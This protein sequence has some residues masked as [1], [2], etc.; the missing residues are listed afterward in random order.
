MTSTERRRDSRSAAERPVNAS[1]L[2]EL[3]GKGRF[4]LAGGRVLVPDGRMSDAILLDGDRIRAIGHRATD[5]AMAGESVRVID[6]S[7]LAVAPGFIDGHT[8]LLHLGLKLSR[9]DLGGAGSSEEVLARVR[10]ALVVHDPERPLVAEGWDDGGWQAGDR[11]ERQELDRLSTRIPI[12]LRRV[13]GHKAVAN[14]AALEHVLGHPDGAAHAAAG[15]IDSAAGTLVEAAAMRLAPIFPPSPAERSTA[16]DLAYRHAAQCGVTGVHD[17]VTTDALRE[18]QIRRR[19]GRLTLRITAHVAIEQLDAL[20]ELGLASGLGDPWLR[21][22]GV[23]LYLDGSLGARTAALSAPYAGR[24]VESGLL[25]IDEEPLAA[26]IRRLDSLGLTAVIHAIGDRAVAAAIDALEGLGAERVREARHRIEHLEL[27]PDDLVERMARC[28]AVA[29]MQP[30][31]VALWGARGG[32]YESV[33]GGSRWRLMN[34]FRSLAERG[35]PLAFGSDCM[36]MGP[37]LGLRGA[38]QHPVEVERLSPAD[39][40]AAYTH[41]SA[42]AGFAERDTGTIEIGKLA[43]LVLL[44]SDPLGGDVPASDRVD[45]SGVVATIVGGRLVFE[46]EDQARPGIER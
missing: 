23:K 3:D 45:E 20:E 44:A 36:P 2:G 19:A 8:H 21:L 16:I 7:R 26:I 38:V 11:I 42:Y 22:G 14:G 32:M 4:L 28:R 35:V 1:T 5:E 25:L 40:L 24:P 46:L 30:N 34:R 13:C 29:S 31:F 15:L 10:S 17:I 12:V 41:G 27:T 18:H 9:P 43:D 37:F 39:A 33:L 6:V